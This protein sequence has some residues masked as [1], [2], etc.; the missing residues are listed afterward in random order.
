M[1]LH[2]DHGQSSPSDMQ[3]LLNLNAVEKASRIY[4]P[5]S[6]KPNT[7]ANGETIEKKPMKQ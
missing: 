7:A 4:T 6:S 5:R 1:E 3:Q 2:E